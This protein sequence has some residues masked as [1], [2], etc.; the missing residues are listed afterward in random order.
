MD[1]QL[2]DG[3]SRVAEKA[4][5]DGASVARREHRYRDRTGATT[6][7][8]K[9]ELVSASATGAEAEFRSEGAATPFINE[10]TSP[11][12]IRPRAAG[13][14]LRWDTPSGGTRFA[15]SVQHPGTQPDPFFDK[16]EEAA[17]RS[18]EE[19]ASA[20]VEQVLK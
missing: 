9:A 1:K 19:G 7:G 16:G 2:A 14:V 5:Q 12:V 8:I 13:G 15:R 10:G 4:A 6:R 17:V 3:Y 20:L 18:L 11:H